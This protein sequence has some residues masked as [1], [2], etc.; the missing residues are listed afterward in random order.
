MASWGKGDAVLVPHVQL[1]PSKSFPNAN[2]VFKQDLNLFRYLISTDGRRESILNMAGWIG[3]YDKILLAVKFFFFAIVIFQK[4]WLCEGRSLKMCWVMPHFYCPEYEIFV[5][6]YSKGQE[7]V[8]RRYM[9]DYHQDS[10]NAW[11]MCSM[12]KFIIHI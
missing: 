2:I 9:A 3:V 1:S 8:E 4:L 6:W 5:K 7:L 11:T 12:S 10:D